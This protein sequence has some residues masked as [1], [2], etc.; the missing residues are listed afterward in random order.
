V[1]QALPEHKVL[2]DLPGSQAQLDLQVLQVSKGLLVPKGFRV[3]KG[4]PERRV[5][6]V[7]LVLKVLWDQQVQ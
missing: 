1:R 6:Q 3:S 2:V 4:L 5:Q 7:I